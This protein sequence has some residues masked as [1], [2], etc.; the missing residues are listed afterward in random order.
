MTLYILSFS[1]IFSACSPSG[2]Y[3]FSVQNSILLKCKYNSEINYDPV[4]IKFSY[5]F[6]PL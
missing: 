2:I 1:Y 4:Y 5:I 3:L 6:S